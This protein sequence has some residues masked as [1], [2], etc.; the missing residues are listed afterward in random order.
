MNKKAVVY[1]RVSTNEQAEH[2]FSLPSQVE[3]CRKYADQNDFNVIAEFSDEYSGRELERPGLDEVRK[4]IG[5]GS[6]DALIV[7]SG[8]RLTRDTGHTLKLRRSRHRAGGWH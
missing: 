1:A 3:A 8:D 7:Y 2:G 4:L 6:I 5:A